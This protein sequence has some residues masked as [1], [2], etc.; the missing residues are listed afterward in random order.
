MLDHIIY[1]YAKV[2]DNEVIFATKEDVKDGFWRCIVEEGKGKEWNFV[3][4]LAQS[5]G[6]K[7][8]LVV[9]ISLQMGWIKSPGYFYIALET[10]RDVSEE[11]VQAA[12]GSLPDH[13][14]LTHIKYSTACK[15]L[16]SDAPNNELLR[17]MIEVYMD[18]YIS[19]EIPRYKKELGH[20]ANVT[21]YRMHSAFPVDEED[22]E[23]PISVKTLMKKDWQ[24]NVEK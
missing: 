1:V 18:D 23:D 3:Y 22:K 16:P 5:E 6:E 2:D 8:K 24:W 14:F 17:F 21:V 11:Y 13:K 9:P 7:A 19:L 12:I 15:A 10:G 4:V 20:L